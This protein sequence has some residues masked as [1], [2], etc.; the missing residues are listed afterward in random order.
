[1]YLVKT[2]Q[3]ETQRIE[4]RSFKNIMKEK[5]KKRKKKLWIENKSGGRYG[6]FLCRNDYLEPFCSSKNE[7][8]SHVTSMQVYAA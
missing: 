5:L 4:E 2:L 3:E 7:R 1:M 8:T 6:D